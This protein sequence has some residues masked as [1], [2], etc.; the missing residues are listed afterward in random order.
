VKIH[1]RCECGRQFKVDSA[2]SGRKS[3]CPDCGVLFIVPLDTAEGSYMPVAPVVQRPREKDAFSAPDHDAAPL[4]KS[5]LPETETPVSHQSTESPD[6]EL[7]RVWTETPL[8]DRMER[9]DA[10]GRKKEIDWESLE[11]D[12]TSAFR[13]PFKPRARMFLGLAALMVGML[14][15]L[16]GIPL[17]GFFAWIL[18]FAMFFYNTSFCMLIVSE[19]CEGAED[20]PEW[21]TANVLAPTMRIVCVVIL[22]LLPMVFCMAK[23]G[24]VSIF[25]WETSWGIAKILCLLAALYFLPMA[26]LSISFHGSLLA[27]GPRTVVPAMRACGTDYVAVTV[28]VIGLTL[29]AFGVSYVTS[30]CRAF[31]GRMHFLGFLV[32]SALAI[33]AF[34]IDLFFAMV[35]SRMLGLLYR[36]HRKELGWEE[37]LS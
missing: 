27:A 5:P 13:Y 8:A 21:P 1:F 7:G 14:N 17:L 24:S 6:D 37:D 33:P 34:A 28:Y 36:R 20:S 31:V 11:K 10:L 26:F 32:S 18:L 12:Y 25:Q 2:H 23:D 30:L 29:I 4:E 15:M 9:E 19:T 16:C 35:V 22:F 3:R